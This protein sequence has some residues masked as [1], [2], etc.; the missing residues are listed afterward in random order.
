MYTLYLQEHLT[1]RD[2]IRAADAQKQEAEEEQRKLFLSAKEKMMKLRKEKET[3]LFKYDPSLFSSSFAGHQVVCLLNL[4]HHNW[5]LFI[6]VKLE[7]FYSS[8]RPRCTERRS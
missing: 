2:L 6:T 3:A 5:S 8:E 7:L 1:N 4:K